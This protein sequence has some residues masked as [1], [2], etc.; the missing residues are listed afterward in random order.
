MG[1][2][3]ALSALLALLFSNWAYAV[4]GNFM[5]DADAVRAKYKYLYDETVVAQPDGTLRFGPARLEKHGGLNVLFL[6]GDPFE[7]A[8]EHGRLLKD[9]ILSGVVPQAAKL[10]Y[11]NAAELYGASPAILSA[12]FAVIDRVDSTALLNNALHLG[13]PDASANLDVAFA[14]SEATGLEMNTVLDAVLNPSVL[15][16]LAA[17]TTTDGT[18]T[19]TPPIDCSEFAAWG[20][21]TADGQLLIARNT[22]FPLNGAYDDHPTVIYF[23]PTTPGAQRYMTVISAGAHNAGILAFNASGLYIGAH[24]IPTANVS[25]NAVPA[26]FLANE[27]ITSAHSMDEALAIFRSHPVESG[28]TYTLISTKENLVASVELNNSGVSVRQATGDYHI[29]TNHYLT[30]EKRGHDLFINYSITEDSFGRYKRIEDLL[31]VA[32]APLDVTAATRILGDQTDPYTGRLTG[33]GNTVAVMDTVSSVVI[34][35]AS[36]K[37]YV[38]N[39]NAP[40]AHNTYIQLPLPTDAAALDSSLGPTVGIDNSGFGV[41]HPQMLAALHAYIA[42]KEAF[43]YHQDAATALADIDQAVALDPSTSRYRFTQATMAMRL[44]DMGQALTILNN[45]LSLTSLSPHE[46]NVLLYTRGRVLAD[47]GNNTAAVADFQAIIAD[48]TVD[49]KLKDGANTGLTNCQ[50]QSPYKVDMEKLPI[51]FQFADFQNY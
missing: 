7:M 11:N 40:V 37:I 14:M 44:G 18:A 39:G 15:M 34:Q 16:I 1:R 4:V 43:E 41:E 12:A 46:R 35:P 23:D 13:G 49:A 5:P 22:D 20:A 28:W 9:D 17:Q 21:R 27:V 50:S 45:A 47:Q 6:H 26:H 8:Y 51:M 3:K 31:Q 36:G 2:I 38:A 30:P 48:P 19:F 42:A 24:T 32:P 25:T 10:V 29:Q 33:L